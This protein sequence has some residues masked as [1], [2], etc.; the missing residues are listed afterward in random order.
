MYQLAAP[1]RNREDEDRIRDREQAAADAAHGSTTKASTSASTGTRASPSPGSVGA[2]P[3]DAT[4]APALDPAVVVADEEVD[5]DE[6]DFIVEPLDA[7]R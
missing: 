5:E 7:G 4:L 3:V 6:V 2:R 1:V